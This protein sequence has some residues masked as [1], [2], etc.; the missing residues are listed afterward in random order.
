[1]DRSLG[2]WALRDCNTPFLGPLGLGWDSLEPAWVTPGAG[3]YV[4][5]RDRLTNC[6]RGSGSPVLTSP[7]WRSPEPLDPHPTLRARC[8]L[9]LAR[10]R[11]GQ[12]LLEE[13]CLGLQGLPP[14]HPLLC[15]LLGCIPLPS[16][17]GEG[18]SSSSL[19]G[20]VGKLRLAQDPRM[21]PSPASFTI[22][23][24]SDPQSPLKGFQAGAPG[25]GCGPI[26]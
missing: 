3:V 20:Q 21:Q 26:S 5:E 8:T 16:L 17:P 2:A 10:G 25:P 14:A 18:M 19:C 23:M 22:L 7:S 15:C 9:S 1:M 12:D 6:P 13:G 11:E 4:C 24:L